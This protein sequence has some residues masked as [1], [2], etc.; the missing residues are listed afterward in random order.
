[1]KDLSK[2]ELDQGMNLIHPFKMMDRVCSLVIDG[3]SIT[4]VVSC[5]MV[6]KMKLPTQRHPNP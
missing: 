5:T 6:D 4:N 1:M 3:R 2:E